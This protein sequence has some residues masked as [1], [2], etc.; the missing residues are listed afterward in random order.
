MKLL[1]EGICAAVQ[2][3]DHLHIQEL[4][5]QAL[6]GGL[7]PSEILN[8]GL[9]AGM[10]V[11]GTK[12]QSGELFIPHMLIAARAMHAALDILK[13]RLIEGGVEPV[14]RA[15]IGTVQNDHH[16][17]GK[18]L[19]AI[20]LEG[21]GFEVIDLG[22]DVPPERVVAA[23]QENV[24]IVGLSALLSTTLPFMA[25][26]VAALHEAGLRNK[27]KVM[28]GGGPVTQTFADRIGSD[29]YAPDAAGAADLALQLLK[30]G[31]ERC[32]P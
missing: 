20:M 2:K 27:V 32:R 4:V 14:G 18:N 31:T 30:H 1:L 6:E 25:D 19:V 8:R 16:D 9:I 29:G 11:V 13:P 17:I 12:F 3:G 21:K 24:Q 26:T 28:V 22:I 15:I 10:D 5:F 23:A 7:A